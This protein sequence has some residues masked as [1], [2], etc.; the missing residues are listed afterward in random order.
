MLR[1]FDEN[2]EIDAWRKR[3]SPCAAPPRSTPVDR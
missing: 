2:C 1:S 3:Q